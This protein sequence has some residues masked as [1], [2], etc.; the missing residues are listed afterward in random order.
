MRSLLLFA[1]GIALGAIAASIVL[2]A[3]GRRDAYA[4]GIM[5]VLQHEAGVLRGSLRTKNCGG[6]DGQRAK[7][8]LAALGGEIEASVFGDSTA[9]VP[10]RE[11][12]QRLHDALAELP[13]APGD[14]VAL[15]PAVAKVGDACDACH[16]QYR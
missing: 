2:N 13:A 12:T 11:Y 15:A 1:L 10:F 3:L 5:Q 14:C 7:S 8:L 6:A 4:R 9:D 16:R